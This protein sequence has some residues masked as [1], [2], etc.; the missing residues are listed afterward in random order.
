L[1]PG[2]TARSATPRS[3]NVSTHGRCGP[4]CR[5]TQPPLSPES[6][7]TTLFAALEIAP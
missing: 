1:L 5:T 7:T 3:V 6:G 4:G 2:A